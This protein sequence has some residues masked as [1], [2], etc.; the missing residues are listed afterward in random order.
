M[1]SP[2]SG[3]LLKKHQY[4]QLRLIVKILIYYRDFI[5]QIIEK[6][7][8]TKSYEWNVKFKYSFSINESKEETLSIH[9]ISIQKQIFF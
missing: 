8:D 5:N 9:V 4:E 3:I 7:L 2:K 6:K 1:L